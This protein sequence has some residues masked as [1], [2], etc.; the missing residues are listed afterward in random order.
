[1]PQRKTN[2]ES[3]RSFRYRPGTLALKEIK[4][5]QST[6]H[7]LTRKRPFSMLVREISMALNVKTFRWQSSAMD[8]L[9]EATESY[10][11]ALFEDTNLAAIHAR[12]VTIM[13]RDLRLVRRIRG[14]RDIGNY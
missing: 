10:M 13:P 3:T 2:K 8:A 14:V 5:Y 9:Q 4:K 12:R 6:T 11:I 7:L 1:L